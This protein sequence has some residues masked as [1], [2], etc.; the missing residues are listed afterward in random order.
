MLELESATLEKIKPVDIFLKV[1]VVELL[2][3]EF[4]LESHQN[5]QGGGTAYKKHIFLQNLKYK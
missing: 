1:V 5:A 3:L 4:I 2:M